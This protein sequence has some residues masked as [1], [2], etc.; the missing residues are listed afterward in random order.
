M[1]PSVDFAKVVPCTEM[2]GD[3]IV[4]T[5]QLE[6]MR[7]EA[8]DYLSSFSWCQRIIDCFYGLGIGGVVAVFLFHIE[9]DKDNVDEWLW[10]ISGDLPSAYL[11]VDQSPTPVS[12]LKTYVAEM[13][14]WVE[15]AKTGRSIEDVIPVN[16]EP[17]PENAARLQKRL[18]FLT[19]EAI[20]LHE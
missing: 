13:R 4:D 11:V 15:A 19:K 20:P 9:P 1:I 10:V 12:A 14:K 17:N 8:E 16:V 2:R 5:E 6:S 3:S 7:K 18:D